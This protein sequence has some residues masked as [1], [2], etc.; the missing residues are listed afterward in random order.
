MQRIEQFRLDLFAVLAEHGCELCD[1]QRARLLELSE[2]K[3]GILEECVY[4]L[5][6][7]SLLNPE[8]FREVYSREFFHIDK[9]KPSNV[10]KLP[11]IGHS[12]IKVEDGPR[13]FTPKQNP[14]AANRCGDF[15]SIAEAYNHKPGDGVVAP[16][17]AVKLL[18]NH[19]R[20]PRV[21]QLKIA[22]REV[23]CNR[24]LQRQAYFFAAA[25]D[26][27]CLALKWQHGETVYALRNVMHEFPFAC[28]LEWLITMLEDI[29][30]LHQ[31]FIA[32]SDIHSENVVVDTRANKA[33]LID[34]GKASK[35]LPGSSEMA[36]DL[37]SLSQKIIS[38]I[39]SPEIIGMRQPYDTAI[40]RLDSA[41]IDRGSP[42][43]SLQALDYCRLL[44]ENI[45]GLS[46]NCMDD[47]AAK[48]LDRKNLTVDDV[49]SG[50][51][52][53]KMMSKK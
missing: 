13:L 9:V 5:R 42:C 21:R 1:A 35:T 17:W 26:D 33:S 12:V 18:H 46:Q 15:G 30:R 51:N 10:K 16:D 44:R 45:D 8:S 40:Q 2:V 23:R 31:Q 34:L 25:K 48:T 39:F 52:R 32:H 22:K 36:D 24:L 14:H 43:S 3:F 27:V 47:I 49:L 53:P 4:R 28:R 20:N 29:V 6:D 19:D 50:C 11:G 37:V 41:L 38:V 7:A